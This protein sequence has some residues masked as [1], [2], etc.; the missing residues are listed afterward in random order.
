MSYEFS[1]AFPICV[2]A[3][4]RLFLHLPGSTF[5]HRII[6]PNHMNAAKEALDVHP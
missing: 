4:N 6:L 1:I 3:S 2:M 5:N